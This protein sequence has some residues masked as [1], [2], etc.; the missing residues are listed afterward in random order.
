ML[1]SR[2]CSPK[3]CLCRGFALGGGMITRLFAFFVVVLMSQQAMADRLNVWTWGPTQLINYKIHSGYGIQGAPAAIMDA[4]YAWFNDTNLALRLNYVGLTNDSSWPSNPSQCPVGLENKVVI[5]HD[6]SPGGPGILAETFE[7]CCNA[8][9]GNCNRFLIETY[10]HPGIPWGTLIPSSAQYDLYGNMVHEFGHALDLAHPLTCSVNSVMCQGEMGPGDTKW[11]NLFRQDQIWVE[12]IY[13]VRARKL[14]YSESHNDLDWTSSTAVDNT[15]SVTTG[16]AAAFG[17]LPG[18][19]PYLGIGWAD[20][21]VPNRVNTINKLDLSRHRVFSTGSHASPAMVFDPVSPRHYVVWSQRDSDSRRLYLASSTNGFS[22][23]ECGQSFG[24]LQYQDASNSFLISAYENPALA[25]DPY[26]DRIFLIWSHYDPGCSKADALA[27]SPACQWFSQ[28]G[29]NYRLF[30]GQILMASISTGTTCSVSFTNLVDYQF[31]DTG[32]AGAVMACNDD[33]SNRNCI[34]TVPGTD[35]F[36]S[37]FSIAF[38][39]NSNG[40]LWSKGPSVKTPGSDTSQSHLGITEDNGTFT[41]S[42]RGLEGYS[43]DISRYLNV[44]QLS[45]VNGSIQFGQKRTLG[46]RTSNGPSMTDSMNGTKMM[47]WAN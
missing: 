24:P 4:S 11:R 35:G 6:E 29:V 42:W 20:S 23:L 30:D 22:T 5:V 13:S 28:G 7:A 31:S 10:D 25:F 15:K 33:S 14:Y 3:L 2:M 17:W 36:N 38:G 18:F 47:V 37:I 12:A 43:G 46:Y 26:S 41:I 32:V 16:T 8:N 9:G 19:Y 40:T 21:Q 1:T 45:L 27:G 34:L 44:H 39:F